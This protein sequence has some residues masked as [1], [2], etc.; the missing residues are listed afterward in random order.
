MDCVRQGLA[1]FSQYCHFGSCGKILSALFAEGSK[2][3]VTGIRWF[4]EEYFLFGFAVVELTT[5]YGFAPVFTIGTQLY[6]VV[7]HIAVG[8]ALFGV[9]SRL[10][11]AKRKSRDFHIATEYGKQSF[12]SNCDVGRSHTPNK[13]VS[14]YATGNGGFKMNLPVRTPINLMNIE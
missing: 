1:L 9:V 6:S 12:P 10:R 14:R 5:R 3:D 11:R 4:V 7:F 2:A 13:R 8:T